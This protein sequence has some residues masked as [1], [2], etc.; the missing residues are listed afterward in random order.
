MFKSHSSVFIWR[1]VLA[2]ALG[3]ISIFWPSITIGAI[4][5]LFAVFAFM[6]AIM[7]GARA[8]TSDRAGPVVGHLLLAVIDV[9]AGVVALA[10][11]GPTALALTI[12]VGIWAVVVG[13][14]E[15]GMA[16]ASGETAG[17][18]A[19]FIFAGLVSIAFGIVLFARPDIGALSLA[20]VFGFFAI[21]Y[22]VSSFV[23]ASVAHDVHDSIV[24][25]VGT[26]GASP[27]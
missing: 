25:Q 2:L 11:P 6:D 7:Q 24:G 23:M 20:Q 22:A 13:V 15:L 21:I 12:L 18:R 3:I 14:G 17:D 16:F 27:A 1:G 9:A 26:P 10:W 8:F 19:L 5:V 4:V